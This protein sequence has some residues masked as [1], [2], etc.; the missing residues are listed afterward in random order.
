MTS[1]GGCGGLEGLFFCP[2]GLVFDDD[3]F[4][5]VGDHGNNRLQMF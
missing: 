1:F 2:N 5:Y 3:G 4:L